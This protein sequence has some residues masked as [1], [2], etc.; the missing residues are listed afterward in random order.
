[1]SSRTLISVEEYLASSFRPDCDYVDGH[2]EERNWGEWSHSEIQGELLAYLLTRYRKDGVRV[3]PELR[4]QVKPQRFRVPDLCVLLK[5]LAS[6]DPDQTPVPV[7]YVRFCR[8]KT[9]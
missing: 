3:M 8:P 9:E 7:Q 5:D 6:A 4:V 2:I 1:M